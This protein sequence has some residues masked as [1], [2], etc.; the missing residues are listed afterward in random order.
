VKP[1]TVERIQNWQ[2][3]VIGSAMVIVSTALLGGAVVTAKTG[4]PPSHFMWTYVPAVAVGVVAVLTA[5]MTVSRAITDTTMPA[6]MRGGLGCTWLFQFVSMCLVIPV[7]MLAA[8]LS[9]SF[10]KTIGWI[11]DNP[12]VGGST[13][14]LYAVLTA[15]LEIGYPAF[16]VTAFHHKRKE[17]ATAMATIGLNQQQAAVIKLL[18]MLNM[19]MTK[20]AIREQLAEDGTELDSQE[21]GNLIDPM[22]RNG[23]LA[24]DGMGKGATYTVIPEGLA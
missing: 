2:L 14:A 3:K 13:L 11:F 7:Y 12:E 16:L 24:K 8:S 21:M 15:S 18:T 17:H 5:S 19:P 1:E 10:D 6:W 22:V 9:K 4:T 20:Q 23:K